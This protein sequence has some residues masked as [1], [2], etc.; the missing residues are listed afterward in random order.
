MGSCLY[1]T[2]G[3]LER[4]EKANLERLGFWTSFR[5][6]EPRQSGVFQLIA[7]DS[8]GIVKGYYSNPGFA[9]GLTSEGHGF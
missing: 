5:R 2:G 3:R 1:G 7:D 4:L 8:G 9:L 6:R